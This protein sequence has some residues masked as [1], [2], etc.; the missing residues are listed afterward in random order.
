MNESGI[1]KTTTNTETKTITFGKNKVNQQ[2]I[3]SSTQEGLKGRA[4]GNTPN[5][6]NANKDESFENQV[7]PQKSSFT[8]YVT[9]LEKHHRKWNEM[10]Y[11]CQ[12]YKEHFIQSFQAL[13]F[14]KYLKPVDQRTLSQ[15]K[16][17]LPKRPTHKGFILYNYL[18]LM[19]D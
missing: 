4:R 6:K 9:S 2:P 15:K 18:I 14:C 3:T 16:V 17:F 11:F 12:I 8:Y 1:S 10:D 7:V 19:I 5:N 13:T